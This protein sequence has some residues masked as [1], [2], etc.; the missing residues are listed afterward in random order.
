M[1][2]RM[3]EWIKREQEIEKI[4]L[5]LLVIKYVIEFSSFRTRSHFSRISTAVFNLFL[6]RRCEWYKKFAIC[7]VHNFLSL[8]FFLFIHI[9]FYRGSISKIINLRGLCIINLRTMT[10]NFDPQT[11][12]DKKRKLKIVFWN[13]FVALLS[14]R[15]S[16]C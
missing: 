3:N 4:E 16:F 1:N 5:G 13:F 8:N 11:T 15:G 7:H 6:I 9:Y 14:R 10:I 2:E 12:K